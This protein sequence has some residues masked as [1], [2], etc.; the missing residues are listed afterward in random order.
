MTTDYQRVEIPRDNDSLVEFLCNDEWPFH[1]QSSLTPDDVVAMDFS[2]PDVSSF[3]IVDDCQK[4][5]LVRLFDLGDVADGAP[6]LDLRIAARHRTRG[7]GKRAT[8][9]TVAH[10]FTTYPELHRVEANTRHDN[11]A[12]QRV[13]SAAGFTHE[14]RLREAWRSDDG[15]R[16]DTMIYG[17]LRTDRTSSADGHGSLG[18]GLSAP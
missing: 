3:W 10:L 4:V 5:G 15:R 13:L 14:G 17:I 2:S 18:A 9:W 12:M 6:L 7:L 11:A 8:C 1:R 16:F